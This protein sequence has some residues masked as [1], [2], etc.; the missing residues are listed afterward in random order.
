MNHHLK[1]TF[2]AAAFVCLTYG[3][4]FADENCT[5]YYSAG[6]CTQDYMNCN[7]TQTYGGDPCDPIHGYSYKDTVV[8]HGQTH[9]NEDKSYSYVSCTCSNPSKGYYSCELTDAPPWCSREAS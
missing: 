5:S 6:I 9:T 3:H 7:N 1:T 2:I 8:V 4:S